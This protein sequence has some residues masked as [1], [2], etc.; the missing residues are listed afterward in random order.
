MPLIFWSALGFIWSIPVPEDVIDRAPWFNWSL[1]AM[2]AA[3]VFYVRLSVHLSVGLI[4]F[5]ALC[6]A[7]LAFAQLFLPC[8]LWWLCAGVFGVAWS[9]QFIGHTIEGKRQ[10]L[11]DEIVFLLIGPAWLMS[12]IYKKLGQAY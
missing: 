11:F 5:M 2:L 12:F 1:V 9:G 7:T 3:A 6:Y 10:S 8:P 4:A